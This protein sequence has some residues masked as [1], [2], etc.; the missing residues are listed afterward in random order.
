M[1]YR[2]LTIVAPTLAERLTCDFG[3]EYS[4]PGG[5]RGRMVDGIAIVE[6]KSR[7]GAARA[8]HVLR[9]LGERPERNCSKYCLGIGLTHPE[10]KSNAF[11]HLLRRHFAPLPGARAM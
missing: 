9:A 7:H 5:A 6:S 3:L 4:A 1:T 8:D 11:R 10:V 2:R